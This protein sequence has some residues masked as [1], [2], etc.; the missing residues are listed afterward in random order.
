LDYDS[1]G[2]PI[3]RMKHFQYRQPHRF[4]PIRLLHRFLCMESEF[5]T[6]I[7]SR[8]SRGTAEDMEYLCNARA[9]GDAEE[10]VTL[11]KVGRSIP[12]RT[13]QVQGVVDKYL[14]LFHDSS[15]NGNRINVLC[16]GCGV[17][18][19]VVFPLSWMRT[20]ERLEKIVCTCLDLDPVA[21]SLSKTLAKENGLGGKIEYIQTD[22]LNIRG[23][24]GEGKIPKSNVLVEIGLHEYREEDDM[25]AWINHYINDAL[26]DDGVYITSSMRDHWGFP[27]FTMDA[28]GWKLI[29]KD[30]KKTVDI[31]NQS[32]LQVIESFYEPLGMHGIVV[33]RKK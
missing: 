9:K 22:V 8:K 2:I 5:A 7:L 20:E 17:G 30:L 25:R 21:I 11:S 12:S 16:L 6:R 15:T 10:I 13:E 29:Y 23:L 28:A 18:R 1:S 24:V 26:T 3:P 14:R 27:R 4:H 32:G 33:A 19:E 31:I